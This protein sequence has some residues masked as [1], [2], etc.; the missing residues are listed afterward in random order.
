MLLMNRYDVDKHMTKREANSL[1][2]VMQKYLK[3]DS[4]KVMYIQKKRYEVR[5]QVNHYDVEKVI[6][7]CENKVKS[8]SGRYVGSWKRNLRVV[9][10]IKKEILC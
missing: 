7:L 4:V 6:S 10:L 8:S 2:A 5:F 3:A 1:I 9:M